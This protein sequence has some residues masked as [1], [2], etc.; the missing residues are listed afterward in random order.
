MD[1][2]HRHVRLIEAGKDLLI[3]LLTCSAIWL[4]GRSGMVGRLDGFLT[5][6][7]LTQMTGQTQTEGRADFARPL[8]M[9]ARLPGT[10]RDGCY[11][12]QYDQVSC[13]A[14]FQSVAGLLVEALSSAGQPETVSRLQWEQMLAAAPGICFDFQGAIPLDVLSVW[15]SG[16]KTDLTAAARRLG[17]TVWEGSVYLFYQDDTGAYACSRTEVV[18]PLH[19]E[20]ALSS[21]SGNGG[22]YAFEREEYAN[23]A[24]DTLLGSEVPRPSVYEADNSV[25]GSQDA[26]EELAEE[27]GFA[28]NTNGVYYAGEWVARSGNDTLR[29]SN[30]GEM[31]YLADEAGG[32]HFLITNLRT[33]ANRADAVEACRTLAAAALSPR[34]G[35]ARLYLTAVSATQTGWEIDFEYSL[36][37]I[38][39]QMEAGSAAHFVVEGDRV[40]RFVLRFRH[41]A[42]TD[43]ELAVLPPVQAAAALEA[44]GLAGEELM[45]IYS[46]GGGDAV[47][48]DWVAVP[49]VGKG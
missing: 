36:D 49:P 44:M 42:G 45:L 21:L 6:D 46:D 32:E 34:C 4:A 27:L 1:K 26:L 16:E 20:D 22:F 43:T 28:I 25:V 2:R 3:L 31:E 9:T 38:P 7:D 37:G 13:D 39:V 29:L 40:T 17:L 8:R 12:A 10:M 30:D 35:E 5:E 48:A 15:L 33:A 19:L 14:L 11:A 47:R 18:N 24:E 23:L 41:Y